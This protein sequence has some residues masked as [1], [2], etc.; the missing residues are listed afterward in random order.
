MKRATF[1]LTALLLADSALLADDKKPMKP[2]IVDPLDLRQ[3]VPDPDKGLTEKY[4]GQTVQYTGELSTW[5]QDNRKKTYWY[6]LTTAIAKQKPGLKAGNT[7][8]EKPEIVTVKVYFE[9]DEK[10]L[11]AKGARFRVKV[12]G[13]G[14]IYADGSMVIQKARLVDVEAL[15][16]K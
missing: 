15:P 3:P 2:V 10:Q 9:Q 5:G 16:K 1:I 11:R 6:A 4:E 7:S 12:E 8:K 13:K 14:E